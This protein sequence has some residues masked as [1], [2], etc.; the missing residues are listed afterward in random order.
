MAGAVQ[1]VT[2]IMRRFALIFAFLTFSRAS[3]ADQL[4]EAPAIEKTAQQEDAPMAFAV[5]SPLS[6]IGGTSVA[7]SLYARVAAHQAVRIN[8]ASYEYG[9]P[10]VVVAGL[11][12]EEDEGQYDGRLL[13]VGVGWMYFPRRVWDGPTLEAGLLRR[14]GVTHVQDENAMYE[15]VDRDTELY[16][17]RA[18][19][20]WSWH[21]A[22]SAMISFAVGASSGYEVGTETDQER[23]NTAPVKHD[24]GQ[25]KTGFE[26]YLRFGWTFGH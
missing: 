1:M 7:G 25:W 2:S 15:V 12:G 21:V 22:D 18:L 5:N 4:A 26:G 19:V 3:F 17:A 23:M 10:G 24:V 9:T 11:L 20:G 16:A 14:S 13:D 6:W 8:V